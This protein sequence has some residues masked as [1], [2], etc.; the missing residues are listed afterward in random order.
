MLKDDSRRSQPMLRP[1]RRRLLPIMGLI[2]AAM[3]LCSVFLSDSKTERPLSPLEARLVG[4]WTSSPQG[5]TR[6]FR[7]DRSFS[8][9]NGQFEGRWSV[10]DSRL[11]VHYWQPLHTRQPYRVD[12]FL[13]KLRR[14]FKTDTVTWEVKFGDDGR[15]HTLHFTENDERDPW[16]WTRRP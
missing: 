14:S 6:I 4:E 3:L 2:V 12:D 16:K 7:P 15:T 1:V 9:A 10:D 11:T 5:S 13:S 8:T